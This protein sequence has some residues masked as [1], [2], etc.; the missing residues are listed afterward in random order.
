MIIQEQF[1]YERE[2]S[3]ILND[4]DEIGDRKRNQPNDLRV[5]RYFEWLSR[6]SEDGSTRRLLAICNLGRDKR[7]GH[8]EKV[9]K[10]RQ[11]LP[12]KAG[13]TQ[14]MSGFE[15][16]GYTVFPTRG[17]S[18]PER[19]FRV[20]VCWRWLAHEWVEDLLPF[21]QGKRLGNGKL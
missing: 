17:G 6:V 4:E 5:N 7:Q 8:F 18:I 14:S 9:S 11:R 13:R 20:D 2:G 1:H 15:T 19:S 10:R 3:E 12:Q 21:I 16:V